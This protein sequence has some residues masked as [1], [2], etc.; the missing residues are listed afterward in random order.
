[1][2]STCATP[3]CPGLRFIHNGV[4]IENV[5][6][7]YTVAMAMVL[8]NVNQ[9]ATDTAASNSLA[10][11][12]KDRGLPMSGA[13]EYLVSG[14]DGTRAEADASSLQQLVAKDA[15][16]VRVSVAPRGMWSPGHLR[17]RLNRPVSLGAGPLGVNCYMHVVTTPVATL[18]GSY[19]HLMAVCLYQC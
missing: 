17:P 19:P 6:N 18:P 16:Q 8:L 15:I 3:R 4:T 10:T 14:A 1:M 9:E 11:L 2:N 7:A 13:M 5:P 12:R